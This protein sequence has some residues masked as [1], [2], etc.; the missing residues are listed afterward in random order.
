VVKEVEPLTA[1]TSAELYV[2]VVDNGL[3]L[4]GE[5][6][7]IYKNQPKHPFVQGRASLYAIAIV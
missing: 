7:S 6:K 4:M 2:Q 3:T 5:V 1:T